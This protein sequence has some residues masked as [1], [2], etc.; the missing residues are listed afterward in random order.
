M[1]TYVDSSVLV[2]VYVP[3]RFSKAARRVVRAANMTGATV[4]AQPVAHR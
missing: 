3:E 1:T 4:E 2:A